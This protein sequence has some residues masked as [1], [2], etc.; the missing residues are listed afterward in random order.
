MKRIKTTFE[1][2]GFPVAIG[3]L[4]WLFDTFVERLN[5]GNSILQCLFPSLISI[6]FL[7]RTVMSVGCVL[8]TMIF[9]Q[10]MLKLRRLEQQ[11]YLSEYAVENT[12]AF[13]MLWTNE[14]GK[15]L[16]VN[17][18]AAEKR[19]YSKQELMSISLFDLCPDHTLEK[20]KALLSKLKNSGGGATYVTQHRRKDGTFVDSI[21]YMQYLHTQGNHYQFAFV[22][23]AANTVDM[24][25]LPRIDQLLPP[26]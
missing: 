15:F 23:D 14:T 12:S 17:K 4:Y 11:L 1:K 18:F 6:S 8:G 3:V 26:V 2:W 22:C 13:A 19:G 16:K 9:E 5:P 7:T 10:G 20:W 21:V 24:A 25:G